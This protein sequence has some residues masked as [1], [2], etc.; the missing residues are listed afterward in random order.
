MVN[1]RPICESRAGVDELNH[2]LEF[3]C[4]DQDREFAVSGRE[5]PSNDR[6]YARLLLRCVSNHRM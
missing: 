5:G 1:P 4:F 2:P 3:K 6:T